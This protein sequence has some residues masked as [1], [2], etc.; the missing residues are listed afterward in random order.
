MLQSTDQKWL[1]LANMFS[2]LENRKCWSLLDV[3]PYVSINV[4][5]C[6]RLRRSTAESDRAVNLYQSTRELNPYVHGQRRTS[7]QIEHVEI[8]ATN[9][10]SEQ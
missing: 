7:K 3:F 5:S 4:G 1:V 9:L 2:A 6:I 8:E 10:K